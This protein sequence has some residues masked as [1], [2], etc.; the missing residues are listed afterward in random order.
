MSAWKGLDGQYHMDGLP[1]VTK[2]RRKPE[3]VGAEFKAICDGSTKI[4]LGLELMEG[5]T[6]QRTK[7]YSDCGSQ[8]TAITLRLCKSYFGSNRIVHAD[9]A[10][11]SVKTL[12]KLKENGL[13]F[14]G[15]VKTANKEYPHKYF[16]SKAR[17]YGSNAPNPRGGFLL[18]STIKGP[19]GIEHDPFY[20]L[21]WYDKKPKMLITNCST[22]LQ[23][24]DSIRQRHHIDS[25]NGFRKTVL[26]SKRIPRPVMVEEF[27]SCF[28]N[29]DIHDHL[30]QG[31]L[32]ME[33]VWLTKKWYHRLFCT[34][35]AICI[36]DSYYGYVYEQ[37][38]LHKDED[39]VMS[40]SLFCDSLAYLMVHNNYN[41]KGVQTRG[42]AEGSSDSGTATDYVSSN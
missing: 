17:L 15:I 25:E 18:L 27:Y 3:G 33:R 29:I 5:K 8:G 39:S 30:R 6:I 22:T 31:S 32:E 21:T 16:Q 41:T 35:Y 7:Q 37:Q 23:G 1:H 2:I 11:S 38:L 28:S 14:M 24:S 12:L 40:L 13:F 9:S 42:D 34:I 36:V 26:T 10:F 4:M 20:A 19:D